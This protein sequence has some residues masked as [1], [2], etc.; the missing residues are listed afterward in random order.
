MFRQNGMKWLGRW[1]A[2]NDTAYLFQSLENGIVNHLSTI[3]H[4]KNQMV[5]EREHRMS[6]AFENHCNSTP[7]FLLLIIPQR[8]RRS[9]TQFISLPME[10]GEFLLIFVKPVAF[11]VSLF[12]NSGLSGKSRWAAFFLNLF[13][14][15]IGRIKSHHE[16]KIKKSVVSN[17]LLESFDYFLRI[18][19][20]SSIL[21]KLGT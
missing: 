14:N 5:V 8:L 16:T 18:T 2:V 21:R 10:V 19:G 13:M 6:I 3:L 4:H 15:L 20:N 12:L 9:K 11:W 1:S 7:F 17:K